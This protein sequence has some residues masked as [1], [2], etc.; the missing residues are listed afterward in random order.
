M[1]RSSLARAVALSLA[2]APAATAA[3][4][5]LQESGHVPADLGHVLPGTLHGGLLANLQLLMHDFP[6]IAHEGWLGDLFDEW[7]DKGW[8][9]PREQIGQIALGMNIAQKKPVDVV[10]L[11]RGPLRLA[12]EIQELAEQAGLPVRWFAYRGVR[13]LQPLFERLPLAIAE[14]GDDIS[15]FH[16][17]RRP[18]FLVSRE[19]V[20][21]A[22]GERVS[23]GD[24]HGM[25]LTPITYVVAGM[26]VPVGTREALAQ[27][28]STQGLRLVGQAAVDWRRNGTKVQIGVELETWT[29]VEAKLLAEWVRGKI[30]SWIARAQNETLKEFL[31][32]FEVE[33]I[34]NHVFLRLSHEWE[35]VQ[36]ALGVM[37]IQMAVTG[38][39]VAD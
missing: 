3:P 25:S 34:Q 19:L 24:K 21:T 36:E 6:G 11:G 32:A 30:D 16:Y 27:D 15:H 1:V 22:Q 13:F 4:P 7:V 10:V 12:E 37:N 5:T 9:D 17:A 8:P 20:E 18:G 39:P 31:E 35:L 14:I 33:A 2:L 23:F 28:P 26:Q 29:P 38:S